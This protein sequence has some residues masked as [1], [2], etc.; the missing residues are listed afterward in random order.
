MVTITGVRPKK[1]KNRFGEP[2]GY[3][4]QQGHFYFLSIFETFKSQ[5][6]HLYRENQLKTLGRRQILMAS[7]SLV[8]GQ[9]VMG[10]LLFSFPLPLPPLLLFL[11]FILFLFETGSHV[12]RLATNSL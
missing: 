12:D 7:A 4:L 5:N 3:W 8:R 1:K 10:L 6:H 11:L 9:E 2:L